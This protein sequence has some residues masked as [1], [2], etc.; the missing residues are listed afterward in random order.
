MFRSVCAGH[1]A[2]RA[3]PGP[4]H[5]LGQRV[6]PRSLPGDDPEELRDSKLAG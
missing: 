1:A 5:R 6:G 2:R 4:N 3:L